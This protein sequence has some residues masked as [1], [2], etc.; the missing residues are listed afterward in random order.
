MQQVHNRGKGGPMVLPRRQID[1]DDEDAAMLQ[2]F[3]QASSRYRAI[4]AT[5]KENAFGFP[6]RECFRHG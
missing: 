5:F 3:V 1:D 6:D 4:A 2:R